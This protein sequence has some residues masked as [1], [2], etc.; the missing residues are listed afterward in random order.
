MGFIKKVCL[1]G[2]PAVGKT[3]LINRYVHNRFDDKYLA[4]IGTKPS[5][6]AMDLDGLKMDLTIWDIAGQENFQNV[7]NS[8][9]RGAQGAIVVCDITRR[10][11]IENLPHWVGR[12]L[13]ASPGKP[14]IIVSNKWDLVD[15]GTDTKAEQ[16]ILE[17]SQH[18]GI[19][20]M[21]SSAKDGSNVEAMFLRIALLMCPR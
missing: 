5:V 4:T 13:A 11:T 14:I 6:K 12:F 3:S 19:E 21:R 17:F 8:Y 16:M 9:F 20:Q 1:L 2:D 7:H 18:G 10:E 15:G